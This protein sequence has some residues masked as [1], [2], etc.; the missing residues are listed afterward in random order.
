MCDLCSGM[1]RETVLHASIL[2]YTEDN[3]LKTSCHDHG[4]HNFDFAPGTQ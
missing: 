1:I 4:Y 2:E 3:C